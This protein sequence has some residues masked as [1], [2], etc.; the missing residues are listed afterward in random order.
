MWITPNQHHP[1]YTDQPVNLD[2][3]Y[4]FYKY[5]YFYYKGDKTNENWYGIAFDLEEKTIIN[6]HFEDKMTRD[7]RYEEILKLIEAKEL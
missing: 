3:A 7:H 2:Y 1:C 6:W 5:D 4:T